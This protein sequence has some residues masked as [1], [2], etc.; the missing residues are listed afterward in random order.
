MRNSSYYL[1]LFLNGFHWEK[2]DKTLDDLPLMSSLKV[3]IGKK[4]NRVK[5]TMPS[6]I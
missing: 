1:E 5:V 3:V 2:R 4:T 6:I